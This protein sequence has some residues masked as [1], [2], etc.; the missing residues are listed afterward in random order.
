MEYVLCIHKISKSIHPLNNYTSIKLNLNNYNGS[1]KNANIHLKT[2]LYKYQKV[3]TLKNLN[4]QNVSPK[5]FM[6]HH[7]LNNIQERVNGFI[8]GK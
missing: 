3:S 2:Y 5:T 7:P 1:G 6:M 8:K 4:R